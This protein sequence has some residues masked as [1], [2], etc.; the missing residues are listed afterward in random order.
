MND[1]RFIALLNLYLDHQIKPAEAAELEAIVHSSPAH[2]RTYEEYCQ[3]QRACVQLGSNARASAPI[4]PRF[5]RSIHDVERKITAPKTANRWFPLQ[6]GGLASLAM[7]AGFVLVIR[8][9]SPDQLAPVSVTKNKSYN[10][11]SEAPVL[12]ATLPV[13]PTPSTDNTAFALHPSLVAIGLG[14][15]QI[16]DDLGVSTP[17]REAIEWMQRVD[18]LPLHTLV[19][20]EQVFAN[21]AMVPPDT[22][23]FRRPRSL[24]PSAEFTGFQL[25]R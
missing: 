4:A 10:A 20:D 15:E 21:Q 25:S 2:R 11:V 17:D 9:N 16:A 23:V 6:V 18:Q 13:P 24:Q 1:R 19:L 5:A 22:H 12:V 14:S 7:A 3:L 8:T